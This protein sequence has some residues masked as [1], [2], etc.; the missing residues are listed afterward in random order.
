[1]FKK[2]HTHTYTHRVKLVAVTLSGFE[3]CADL[4][5]YI[6]IITHIYIL[7]TCT[8]LKWPKADIHVIT[9]AK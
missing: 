3:K 7:Y 8:H 5:I 4:Y 1:M 2:I 6:Y 9:V